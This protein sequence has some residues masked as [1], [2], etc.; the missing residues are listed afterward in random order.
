MKGGLGFAE[1]KFYLYQA[2]WESHSSETEVGVEPLP[3]CPW[4][5]G[6]GSI[7]C[8]TYWTCA[9]AY[10]ML[11]SRA[12]GPGGKQQRILMWVLGQGGAKIMLEN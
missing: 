4:V 7:S 10:W 1:R 12:A 6:V 8:V 11:R 9:C 3:A 2:L 5:G